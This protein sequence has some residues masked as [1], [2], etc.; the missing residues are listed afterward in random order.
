VFASNWEAFEVAAP[1]GISQVWWEWWEGLFFDGGAFWGPFLVLLAVFPDGFDRQP[2]RHVRYARATFGIVGLMFLSAVLVDDVTVGGVLVASPTGVGVVPHDVVKL[3]GPVLMPLV[4]GAAA[5]LV[6]RSRRAHGAARRQYRWVLFALGVIL[7]PVPV[8]IAIQE[9]TGS[10]AGWNPLILGYLLLPVAFMVAILRYRLYDIDRI[11]SR[12]VTYGVVVVLLGTTYGALVVALR[13]LLPIEGD[14][15]V[16]VS[17][18]VVALGFL[19]LVRRVQRVVDRRFFRS[20]Y[21]AGVVVSGFADDLRGSLDLGEVT[22]RVRSMIDEVFAP[23]SV[24]VWV[25]AE[26]DAVHLGFAGSPAGG[27]P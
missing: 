25:A 13:S 8:A 15:P 5:L 12:T 7:V 2:I 14:L 18:L 11:V 9:L 3:Q 20:R 10:M 6:L 26:P 4:L 23:E 1:L 17:T 27:T 22:G 21:D 24:A 19:P 16:A